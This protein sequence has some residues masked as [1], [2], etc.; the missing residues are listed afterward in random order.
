V[1]ENYT[2]L[3]DE[4]WRRRFLSAG[5]AHFKAPAQRPGPIVQ[6]TLELLQA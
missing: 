5:M 4:A 2:Q 6:E 3:A 1:F